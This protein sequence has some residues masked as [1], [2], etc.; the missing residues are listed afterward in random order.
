MAKLIELGGKYA[1]GDH[2]FT[3]VD[4]DVYDYLNQWRWKAKWNGSHNHI[5]AVRSIYIDGLCT[6]VRMHRA[7]LLYSGPLDIDHRNRDGL[8]NRRSNLRV[9]TRKENLANTIVVEREICC[10]GCKEV[11]FDK[12]L[13]TGSPRVY[14][15][16]E[17]K[18]S[19]NYIYEA[20]PKAAK[21]CSH[22]GEAF[23]THSPK[24]LFCS[25]PCSKAAKWIRQREMGTLPP[26]TL[27]SAERAR[28]WRVKQLS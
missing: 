5:Y 16:D 17:C 22:C 1:V 26:S 24:A 11:F 20:K 3:V 4:D 9:V 25:E 2:Q 7:I 28:A 13:L 23:E 12:R 15:S 21:T 6:M 27:H 19:A 14:C 18:P 10:R 8:D